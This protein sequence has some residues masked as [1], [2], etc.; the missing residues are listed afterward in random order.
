MTEYLYKSF[1]MLKK[2]PKL[3]IV[4]D[5]GL[6]VLFFE[7]YI[8][9]FSMLYNIVWLVRVVE[10]LIIIT[11]LVILIYIYKILREQRWEG[12]YLKFERQYTID[13]YLKWLISS[14]AVLL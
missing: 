6:R 13:R 5:R 3:A 8:C 9:L 14:L 1:L 4:V 7:F 12:K 2:I 10:V 11:L